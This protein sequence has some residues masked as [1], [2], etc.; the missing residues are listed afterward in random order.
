MTMMLSNLLTGMRAEFAD[1]WGELKLVKW[2]LGVN[3]AFPLSIMA[4][5]LRL[6]A[7]RPSRWPLGISYLFG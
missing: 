2:M 5:L 4:T 7:N 3:L 1:V 6:L